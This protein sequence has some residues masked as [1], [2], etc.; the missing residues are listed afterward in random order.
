M[1]F[2]KNSLQD[3]HVKRG[4]TCL[5]S[6]YIKIE[7]AGVSMLDDITK[8]LV[9]ETQFSRK[10]PNDIPPRTSTYLESGFK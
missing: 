2:T 5:L 6:K 10:Y 9:Q 7:S 3:M 8:R 4:K 1:T